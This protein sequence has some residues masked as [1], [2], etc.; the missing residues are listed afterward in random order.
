[1]PALVKRFSATRSWLMR[2]IWPDEACRAEGCQQFQPV[3]ADILEF[4]GDDI[5]GRGEA[6][7]GVGVVIG[8]DGD[9]VGD[10]RRRAV[11]SLVRIWT[12]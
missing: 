5:D 9:C 7:Q 3:G 1:M 8:A 12:R 4:E 6:A 2:R 10:L 11:G